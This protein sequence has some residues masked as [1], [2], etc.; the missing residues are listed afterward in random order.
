MRHSVRVTRVMLLLVGALAGCGNP[1][2]EKPAEQPPS[3]QPRSTQAAAGKPSALDQAFFARVVRKDLGDASGKLELRDYG[4][5]IHPGE[6]TPTSVTFRLAA[7]LKELRLRLFISGLTP[8]GIAIPDAGTVN[9]EFIADGRALFKTYI[10]RNSS[11]EKSFNVSGVRDLVIRV[12]NANGK[13][14]WDWFFV[15]VQS[16]T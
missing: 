5:L 7:E 13:P 16:A 11:M 2:A 3:T 15:S 9:V 10:D 1:P 6:T 14:W 4:I 8:E 12:D